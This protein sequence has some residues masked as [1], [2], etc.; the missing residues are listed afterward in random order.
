MC[1]HSLFVSSNFLDPIHSLSSTHE[2]CC[3][4]CSFSLASL[5]S[6]FSSSFY[7]TVRSCVIPTLFNGFSVS[8]ILLKF[9]NISH[10][11]VSKSIAISSGLSLVCVVFSN[12]TAFLTSLLL[13]SIL[14]M[15]LHSHA[16]FWISFSLLISGSGLSRSPK[17]MRVGVCRLK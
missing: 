4:C 12:L 16:I 9:R 6:Y 11:F 2:I 10:F 7:L 13:I 1:V 3:S 8:L 5:I 17:T 14:Q 15:F